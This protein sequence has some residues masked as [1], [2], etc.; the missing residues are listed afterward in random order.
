MTTVINKQKENKLK[1]NNSNNDITNDIINNIVNEITSVSLNPLIKKK[2]TM[3]DLFAGTGAF[4]YVANKYNID[5]VYANDISDNSKQIYDLN[6]TNKLDV[7]DINNIDIAKIGLHDILCAGFP[8][9]PYSIAG[10]K[11]GFNDPRSNVFWKILDIVKLYKPK[12]I[13][14]KNVKNLQSHDNKNTFKAIR[15]NLTDIGYHIKH[16]ILDTS[17]ITDVPQHRERIYIMCF[18]DINMYNNFNFD[19]P[20]KEQKKI[21]EL[22]QNNVDD[23]YYYTDSYKVYETVKNGVTKNIDKNVLYQYRRFY[24]REN[25]NNKCPTLTKN[26]ETG[27]HNV[28]LLLDNKGIRK[29]TPTE[30]FNLQGFPID[31]VLPNLS[32]NKLYGLAGNAVSVPVVDLIFKK[33]CDI[34]N[35][36]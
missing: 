17:V 7:A 11:L 34:M 29:L 6:H 2:I 20:Q 1:N 9:Q 18:L 31:Y 35:V 10:K 26:M 8:C 33:I 4:S 22:L 12:I 5:C 19:F 28:P 23:K 30:C 24:V 32:D 21:S 25:K 27:G 3:I 36:A 14:L 15:K 13:I 16:T